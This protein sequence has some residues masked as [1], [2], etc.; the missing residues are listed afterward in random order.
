LIEAKQLRFEFGSDIEPFFCTLAIYDLKNQRKVT[1]DFHFN[2]NPPVTTTMMNPFTVRI[3]SSESH[4]EMFSDCCDDLI[5]AIK[6][7]SYY[8]KELSPSLCLSLAY[9][10]LPIQMPIIF[11][12]SLSEKFSLASLLMNTLTR[13]VRHR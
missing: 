4:L 7:G 2:V 9:S 3:F 8:R 1:E 5:S 11:W 6:T 13:T 12:F 10:V